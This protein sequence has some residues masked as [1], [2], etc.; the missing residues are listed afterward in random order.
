MPWTVARQ[1]PQSMGFPRPEYWS[2]LH[3]LLPTQGWNRCLLHCQGVTE[4]EPWE[5]PGT[6]LPPNLP[7]KL[8]SEITLSDLPGVRTLPQCREK[9]K[10]LANSQQGTEACPATK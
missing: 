2:G 5:L 6:G 3:F 8:L 9:L 1:A 10:S 7:P 4:Q